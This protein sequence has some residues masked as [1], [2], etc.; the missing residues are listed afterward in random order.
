ML[1]PG[2]NTSEENFLDRYNNIKYCKEVFSFRDKWNK[3]NLDEGRSEESGLLAD[4]LLPV[5]QIV[6]EEDPLT[7]L[8]SKLH[9]THQFY[10]LE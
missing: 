7:N 4:Y 9:L 3:A 8:R 10:R 5:H 6:Q 1:A 2:Q